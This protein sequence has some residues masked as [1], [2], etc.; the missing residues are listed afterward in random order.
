MLAIHAQKV[1][2][3][4]ES[5]RFVLYG[6]QVEILG[7]Y[8]SHFDAEPAKLNPFI[9]GCGVFLFLPLKHSSG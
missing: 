5:K 3:R 1:E 2:E 8:P 4:I 7:S 9:N 6:L